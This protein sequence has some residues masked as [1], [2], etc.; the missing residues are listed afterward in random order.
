MRGGRVEAQGA[1]GGAFAEEP[2]HRGGDCEVEQ[3]AADEAADDD[4]GDGMQDFLSRLVRG[5]EQRD[6]RDAGGKR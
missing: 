6:E 2:E 4:D 1:F 3:G 5:E